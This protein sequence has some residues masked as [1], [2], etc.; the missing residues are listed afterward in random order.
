MEEMSPTTRQIVSTKNNNPRKN[1]F[2]EKSPVTV[3]QKSNMVK[4]KKQDSTYQPKHS[5]KPSNQFKDRKQN[6]QKENVENV[7]NV[8][9]EIQRVLGGRFID[10]PVVFSKDS[11]YFFCCCSNSVKVVSVET[12]EIIKT[13]S[14]SPEEIGSHKKDVTFIKMDPNNDDQLYSAS[15][16]GTIK[17]WNYT[18]LIREYYVGLPILRMEM[19][20]AHPNQFFI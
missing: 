12:G 7:D 20:A 11:K 8:K 16:D 19:H 10:R 4:P 15:L 1:N 3:N 9:L 5:R 13:F 2:T 14:I 17:L 18:R 6:Q